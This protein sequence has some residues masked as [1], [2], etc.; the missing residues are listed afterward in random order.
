MWSFILQKYVSELRIYYRQI[1]ILLTWLTDSHDSPSL[2]LEACAVLNSQC[3]TCTHFSLISPCFCYKNTKS[4]CW[5]CSL[6]FLH[7]NLWIILCIF[8]FVLCRTSNGDFW[9][10]ALGGSGQL[11]WSLATNFC[12]G[13][14]TESKPDRFPSGWKVYVMFRTFPW[15]CQLERDT[16]G[17]I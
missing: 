13:I 8:P 9:E 14:K 2:F 17:W 16:C 7:L 12:P 15:L 1:V 6:Y 11:M 5:T 3:Y 10:S 4:Q